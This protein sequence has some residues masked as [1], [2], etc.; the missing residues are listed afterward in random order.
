MDFLQRVK[1]NYF[2]ICVESEKTLNSQGNIEKENQSWG[3]HNARFQVVLQSC[4]HQDSV[5]PAQKQ[6]QR[7]MEQNRESRNGPSTLWSLIFNKARKT[8]HWKKDSLFNKWCRENWTATCRRMK[9]GH[10]H[11][12]T[13]D[14]KRWKIF[15]AH[16]L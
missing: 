14:T 3:H 9:L 5:V 6:T 7:S 12:L 11:S 1:T 4:G 10:S 15:H 2:M 16:G 8:I 13:P